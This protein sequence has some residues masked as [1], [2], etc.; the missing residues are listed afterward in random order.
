MATASLAGRTVH[1]VDVSA[2]WEYV[3]EVVRY[4]RDGYWIVR[5]PRY[6]TE[7][8]HPEGALTECSPDLTVALTS[9]I[10][11]HP[12]D[13]NVDNAVANALNEQYG[14]VPFSVRY[15]AA[16]AARAV[17]TDWQKRSDDH[18]S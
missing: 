16:R 9:P 18:H 10:R 7:L 2:G 15:R 5:E 6:G 4:A 14:F 17:V 8:S 11:Y 12:S 13:T 1:V 3:G